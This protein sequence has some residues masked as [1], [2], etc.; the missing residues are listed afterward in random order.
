MGNPKQAL[1][2]SIVGGKM[3]NKSSSNYQFTRREF[4]ELSGLSSIA[5][6]LMPKYLSAKATDKSNQSLSEIAFQNAYLPVID[7]CDVL[8]V[9]G[10][11]AGVSAALEFAKAGKKVVLV[12]RRIYLGREMTST[13]RPWIKLDE[14]V[15]S[16]NLPIRK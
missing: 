16:E 3:A 12:E 15:S 13:C 4:I 6:L 10:S 14:N 11:F 5:V 7:K 9:G 2:T 1:K 8:I